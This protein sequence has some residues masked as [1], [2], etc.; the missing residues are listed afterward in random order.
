MASSTFSEEPSVEDVPEVR[1]SF[2]IIVKSDGAI[3]YDP[4]ALQDIIGNGI[5]ES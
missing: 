3:D 1:N 4:S 2:T 5:I